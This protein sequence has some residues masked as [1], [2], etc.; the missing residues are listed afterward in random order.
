[1]IISPFLDNRFEH[2]IRH[3]YY[4]PN[5]LYEALEQAKPCM[6]FGARGTGKSTLLRSLSYRERCLNDGLRIQLQKRRAAPF[7]GIYIKIP[8]VL[9]QGIREWLGRE[10]SY[11]R[12]AL[13]SRYLELVQLQE[14]FSAASEYLINS[15][16]GPDS[17][18]SEAIAVAIMLKSF[19]SALSELELGSSR[20]PES[21]LEM[22]H[23]FKSIRKSIEY[24]AQRGVS[25][26]DVIAKAGDLGQLGELSNS[27]CGCLYGLMEKY[28]GDL[29]PIFKVCMDEAECLDEIGIRILS[30]W[31]R[32]S[33]VPL[34]HVVS[35]VSKRERQSETYIPNLTLQAADVN[36]VDLD[37]LKN[38]DFEKFAEGVVSLRIREYLA[39][40]AQIQLELSAAYVFNTEKLFGK[41]N[42]NFLLEG[43][44]KNSVA[45]WGKK[46]LR[47]AEANAAGEGGAVDRRADKGGDA[48][49]L[50]I[51]ETYL[52]E[53]LK[54]PVID[55]DE[56]KWTK[57]RAS[58]SQARKP[59]VAAYLSICCDLSTGPLYAY[60]DMIFQLSDGCIRDFLLLLQSIFEASNMSVEEFVYHQALRPSFQILGYGLPR[61]RSG[62]HCLCRG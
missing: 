5:N 40:Y 61:K 54:T 60:R 27:L 3:L 32:N 36:V 38:N 13:F 52:H 56:P 2:E 41:L 26:D 24:L 22:S 34:C 11:G 43:I 21:L 55:R 45:P 25:P 17:A 33:K 57:R 44:L 37:S 30:T 62:G 47:D 15:G 14:I 20:P 9:V 28:Q 53:R 51:Y 39:R 6:L 58:S 48:F 19:R 29:T 59:M 12:I 16:T 31:I 50:P 18:R 23:L 4:I 46:L 7:L 10:P 35:F 1:M 8:E 49:A 42:I